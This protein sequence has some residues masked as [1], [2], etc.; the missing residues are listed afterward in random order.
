MSLTLLLITDFLSLNHVLII[1]LK[2]KPCFFSPSRPRM[3]PLIDPKNQQKNYLA[4]SS[5]KI[6]IIDKEKKINYHFL[7]N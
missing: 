2:K 3:T 1:R 6:N 7:E 5:T 4:M